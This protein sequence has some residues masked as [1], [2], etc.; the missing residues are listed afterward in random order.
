[1]GLVETSQAHIHGTQILQSKPQSKGVSLL[2]GNRRHSSNAAW[3]STYLP[4]PRRVFARKYSASLEGRQLSQ[5]AP[6]GDSLHL[7]GFRILD[8]S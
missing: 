8:A 5:F 7:Q 4:R 2:I 3:L 1:M 6:G